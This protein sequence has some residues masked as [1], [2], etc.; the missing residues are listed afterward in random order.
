[1]FDNSQGCRW[2]LL[3]WH[4]EYVY[5]YKKTAPTNIWVS[6]DFY[7]LQNN[8][9]TKTIWSYPRCLGWGVWVWVWHDDVIK[10]RHFPRYWSFVR[11][12]HR[13]PVNSPHKGQ[14]RGALMFT[15]I[16]VW[17][18]GCVNNR[19]AGDLRRHCAHYGVTVMGVA[20]VVHI[21]YI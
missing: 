15:L 1:M 8:D 13:S 16:C 18:N 20:V 6:T 10:W 5:Y 17:I 19:K 2:H 3:Y 12:I 14:W 4:Q 11:G 9:P 21:L 7:S